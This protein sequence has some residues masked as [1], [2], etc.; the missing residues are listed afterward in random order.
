MT[1]LLA[2]RS[3]E[4]GRSTGSARERRRRRV[5]A[6][7]LS[8][9]LAVPFSALSYTSATAAERPAEQS[10][11]QAVG[12]A[13]SAADF[14]GVNW[15]RPEDNFV[16]GPVV[17]EGL[18]VSDDYATVKAKAS[19]VYE[20]FRETSGANTVRLP[21]NTHSVPGT[22]WGD[23][24]AGAVDAATE[25]GFKVILSYWEDGAS[26]DG[27]I[28]DTEAFN[29]MWDAVASRW[30]F[31]GRVHFE[32][33]NEPH[34]YSAAEWADVAAQWIADRPWVPRKRIFVS[35]HGYNGDVTSVCHDSRLAG[36]YLSL[37][38]YAFQFDSMSYDEWREL[39]DSRIGECGSRTV[40]DEF[41]APMDDGRN[42]GEAGS[43]DNFVRY[44]RAATDAVRSHDMGA[45][46]WP[47]LGGKHTY[48]P[49]YDWYSLYAL[50]G[51][52]TDLSLR[53]RNDS[54]IDR[55][56]HAWD[57]AGHA[58]PAAPAAGEHRSSVPVG[59]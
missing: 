29:A 22:E 55:L 39:F 45:V 57:G 43:A 37:H 11:G 59:R 47:A 2:K 1:P 38:L 21:I 35:G 9:F 46:Y 44:I 54:M 26:S 31:D 51:S 28:A 17:P 18:N 20:E 27:R 8:A 23:A 41:G 53:V 32:P 30:R 58:A 15:A 14:Q 49:D 36:T 5:L 42:Y 13:H 12:R 33:M 40:L 50:E 16:D 34:G 56:R 19:A 3:P 24:Y 25:N 4:R 48:R 6:A 52:G 10:A 7:T